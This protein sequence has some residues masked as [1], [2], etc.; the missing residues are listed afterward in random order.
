LDGWSENW[1]SSEEYDENY[2]MS[3]L[4]VDPEERL[5]YV[6]N[7]QKHTY[8]DAFFIVPLY[9]YGCYAWRE[10]HFSGWGDWSAHPGRGLS[11]FWSANDLFFDLEPILAFEEEPLALLDNIGGHAGTQVEVTGYAWDPEGR[12]MT[13]S[14]EFGDGTDTTGTVPEDGEISETHTYATN[15][16]YLMNLTVQIGTELEL[17]AGN[18]AVI[19]ASGENAPPSNLRVITEPKWASPGDTV[20]IKMQGRDADGDDLEL[21]LDFDDGSD[22]YETSV[23]G[24]LDGFETSVDHVYDDI[25]V[26][27][28]SL[29]ASDS[30][31][32]SEASYGFSVAAL[33]EDGGGLGSLT[34][35]LILV[36]V[37]AAIAVLIILSRRKREKKE[38][39]EDIRLP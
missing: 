21:T 1:Y 11:N 2:T 33:E 8:V 20:T 29:L 15:A 16:T 10:D 32:S 9:P 37:V 30:D 35:V 17:P 36:V 31:S 14:L 39:E 27:D 4:T 24:T 6:V 34:M 25:G 22:V 18:T 3:L 7:C 13:Y 19:V 5:Q 26:W 12:D 28:I 38:D 23:T